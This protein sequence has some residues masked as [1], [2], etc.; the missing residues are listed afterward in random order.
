ML[1]RNWMPILGL[2]IA[3]AFVGTLV[4]VN[5]RGSS[6]GTAAVTS[7]A[8]V[9]ASG[10]SS[11]SASPT[12]DPAEAD[13]KAAAQA[14]VR[15]YFETYRTGSAQTVDALE[16]ADSQAQGEAGFP[17]HDINATHRTFLASTFDCPTPAVTVLGSTSA[18]AD[19]RCSVFGTEASWPELKPTGTKTVTVHFVLEFQQLSGRWLVSAQQ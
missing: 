8:S 16:V 4:W 15:A 5:A 18:N 12:A 6:D 9:R 17:I 14:W 13:V 11:P 19:L 2:A 10:T 3:A 1:R 7:T